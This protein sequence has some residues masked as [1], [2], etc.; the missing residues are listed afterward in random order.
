MAEY[1]PESND[2]LL[3]S[4]REHLAKEPPRDAGL[5]PAESAHETAAREYADW[6]RIRRA[7]R[8]LL[9]P[10]LLDEAMGRLA[11]DDA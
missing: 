8:T 7:Y 6:D 1:R 9:A 4:Y 3:R 5:N 2:G 11:K 10:R